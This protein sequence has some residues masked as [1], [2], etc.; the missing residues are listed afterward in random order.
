MASVR[1]GKR[2]KPYAKCPGCL[3]LLKLRGK[4]SP[5]FFQEPVANAMPAKEACPV[6]NCR[7]NG[8]ADPEGFRPVLWNGST[9]RVCGSCARR[10]VDEWE[11]IRSVAEESSKP[12]EAVT[13][14]EVSFVDMIT[15]PAPVAPTGNC[16]LSPMMSTKS[17]R[18]LPFVKEFVGRNRGTVLASKEVCTCYLCISPETWPDNI[19]DHGRHSAS[20][21]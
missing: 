9:V 13:P 7:K 14:K 21:F 16:P 12:Q 6:L 3:R 10:S 8:K 15:S 18:E 17:R 19:F 4:H 2:T 1:G 5:L 11:G 20:K